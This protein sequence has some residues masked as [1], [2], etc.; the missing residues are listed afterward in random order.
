VIV[1]LTLFTH[2]NCAEAESELNVLVLPTSYNL[3]IARFGATHGGGG[4]GLVEGR[5]KPAVLD[6]ERQEIDI[7]Q[8]LRSEQPS[9]VEDQGS[10]SASRWTISGVTTPPRFGR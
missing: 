2:W 4:D 10:S 8:L 5:Q 6:G 3:D 9:V 7:G 1:H